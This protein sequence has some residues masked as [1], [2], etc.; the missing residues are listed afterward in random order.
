[1][2]YAD[3]QSL[4]DLIGQKMVPVL[5]KAEAIIQPNAGKSPQSLVDQA[6]YFSLLRGFFVVPTIEWPQEL[7]LW[8]EKTIMS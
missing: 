2:D 6:I 1:M 3:A 8:L 4:I 5:E 7:K